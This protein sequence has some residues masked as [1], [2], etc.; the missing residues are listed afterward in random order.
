MKFLYIF[1]LFSN[2]TFSQT[3]SIQYTYDYLDGKTKPIYS[4]W[5]K[6][7]E[8]R[9]N[10]NL[11]YK[12][13]WEN[14]NEDLLIS[15]SGYSPNFFEM[16]TNNKLLY[17]KPIIDNKYEIASMFYWIQDEVN[18]N[19]ISIVKYIV[20]Y[21]NGEYK[22]ENFLENSTQ[23]WNKKNV[24]LINY[25]YPKD[26][27]FSIKEAKKANKFIYRLNQLFDLN[28]EKIDYYIAENCD[29]QTEIIGLDYIATKGL[30]KECG[31]FDK[32]K[33]ILLSTY[34]AGEF[35]KHELIHLINKKYI[36]SHYLFLTGLSV[37][38]NSPK[39]SLGKS[40]KEVFKEFSKFIYEKPD[41]KLSFTQDFPKINNIGT[42]Y[43][44]SAILVDEV[45]ER[46]GLELLK[47][48]MNTINSD[49]QLNDFV[50]NVLNIK[51]QNEFIRKTSLK[52]EKDNFKFKID[53]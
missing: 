44:I 7:V 8:L 41:L 40:T 4:F 1:L 30:M 13:M 20:V 12:N 19:L 25:F 27:K 38:N 32:N 23:N 26:Y 18:V 46:G 43:I 48:A 24:G 10:N 14:G 17:I 45:L 21:K 29:K 6:Y 49:D 16:Y 42:E 33:N 51:D 34:Y 2:F 53:L 36:N 28:N 15:L 11:S 3:T 9:A 50:E 35:Y 47:E 52:F 31:Y 39:A 22:L 37:Y 5:K